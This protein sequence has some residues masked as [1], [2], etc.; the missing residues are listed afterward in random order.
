MRQDWNRNGYEIKYKIQKK[1]GLG[2]LALQYAH[3]AQSLPGMTSSLCP[4]I[5]RTQYLFQAESA[6]MHVGPS[7]DSPHSIPLSGRVCEDARRTTIF[8]SLNGGGVYLDT[9]PPSADFRTTP[10]VDW[11]RRVSR[12]HVGPEQ[13]PRCARTGTAECSEG[14]HWRTRS[15]HGGTHA[16]AAYYRHPS[17]ALRYAHWRRV[18]K[19]GQAHTSFRALQYAH[20]RRVCIGRGGQTAQARETALP[21]DTLR[22]A[23]WRRVC[24]GRGGRGRI[25][26]IRHYFSRIIGQG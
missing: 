12:M 10:T 13:P 2:R 15:L 6:K 3:S 25:P 21:T 22:Y 23:H 26:D 24:I 19:A 7:A 11:H 4:Q 17:R 14:A 16:L 5:P 8:Y 9:P 20:W 1:P 18:C